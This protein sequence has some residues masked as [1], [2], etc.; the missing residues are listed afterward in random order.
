MSPSRFGRGLQKLRGSKSDLPLLNDSPEAAKSMHAVPKRFVSSP[1]IAAVQRNLMHRSRTAAV[2]LALFFGTL[3]VTFH[4]SVPNI[5]HM[6]LDHGMSAVPVA[7]VPVADSRGYE[8]SH[9]ASYGTDAD[10]VIHMDPDKKREKIAHAAAFILSK[11]QNMKEK[12]RQNILK[13]ITRR[14]DLPVAVVDD[15]SSDEC[16][17]AAGT[18][19][20]ALLFLTRGGIT[21]EDLWSLWFESA[22]DMLPAEAVRMCENGADSALIDG[23][24]TQS[25]RSACVDALSRRTTAEPDGYSAFAGSGSTNSSSTKGGNTD[26]PLSESVYQDVISM[27]HLF[28]V[29]VHVPPSVDDSS[30]PPVWRRRIVSNRVEPEWGTHTLVEATRHLIWESFKDPANQRFVL[31]SESDVPL[32]DPLTFYRQVMAEEKSRVD[33]WLH[34]EVDF[35][36]WNRDM[37]NFSAEGNIPKL[38]WR[39]SSQWFMLQRKHAEIFLDDVALFRNMEQN[40]RTGINPKTLRPRTCYSVR[41][42]VETSSLV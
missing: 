37:V 41:D 42:I 11:F 25:I 40:C 35:Y 39:K 21:H 23:S 29:Y 14:A 9:P 17:A 18:P 36:R 26:I 12:D 13:P 7:G 4:S 31:L 24:Q 1:T 8:S 30:V 3:L 19:K 22:A 6:E 28:N 15:R 38:L 33:A 5:L 27:Q 16:A 34:E 2:L 20:V 10:A 32:Y